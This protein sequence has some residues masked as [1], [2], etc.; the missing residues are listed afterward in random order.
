[1]AGASEYCPV[2]PSLAS[3][4]LDMI[5]FLADPKVGPQW[6]AR[7]KLQREHLDARDAFSTPPIQPIFTGEYESEA[8][9]LET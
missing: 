5:Y 4:T 6:N 7:E 9:F 8:S 3:A 1:L 2:F